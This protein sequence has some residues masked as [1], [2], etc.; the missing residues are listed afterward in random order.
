MLTSSA[1][2][3]QTHNQPTVSQSGK[4]AGTEGFIGTSVHLITTISEQS[5]SRTGTIGNSTD[6][7][8]SDLQFTW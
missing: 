7:D 8:R 1:L 4:L 2:D 5:Q 3:V 6:F